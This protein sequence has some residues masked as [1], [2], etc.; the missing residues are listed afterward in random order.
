MI[1]YVLD[2]RDYKEA[3]RRND[4]PVLKGKAIT[5]DIEDTIVHELL[6]VRIDELSDA[7]Q[8]NREAIEEMVVVRLTKALLGK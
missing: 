2:P 5:E 1:I 8:E 4:T 7:T 3:A 6:H